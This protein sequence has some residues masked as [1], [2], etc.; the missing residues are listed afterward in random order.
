MGAGIVDAMG[1]GLVTPRGEEAA[2]RTRRWSF[3]AAFAVL[4]VSLSSVAPVV[5]Q[6]PTTE[7]HHGI[8][9]AD[10]DLS[11]DSDANFYRFANGGWLDRTTIP[12]DKAAYGVF[13][14]LNDLTTRQL[15]DLLD[16]LA[17]G[18]VLTEGSDEWKAVRLYQQGIDRSTRNAQGIAPVKPVLD[19]IDALGNLDAL[20]RF[21][22]DAAFKGVP[23]LFPIFVFGDLQDST[24][25]AAYVGGPWLGLP[26]R[27]Y[28]LEDDAANQAVR[29]AYVE[30]SA[31]L[32]T[33]AGH[34]EAT[35]KEAAQ[36]VYDLERQL[37]EPTLTREEQQDFSLYYNP[38]SIDELAATYPAMDW[39]GYVRALGLSGVDRLIVT[40]IK[41]LKA[42]DGIV[43]QAP[44]SALKDYLTLQVLWGFSNNLSDDIEATAF[45]FQGK[46]LGGAQQMEPIEKRALEQ[47]N[48]VMGEAVGK[49]YVAE[50]FPPAA[51]E[52]ITK[53]VD[54]LLEA[55]RLR[56]ERNA[57]MSP[58][59]KANALEKL[60]KIGVKV[61]Y[62]DK[63][64]DY[65]AVEIEGSYAL[66]AL[67]A[68]NAEYRRQLAL[69]GKPVD[70]SEWTFAPQVVNAGYDPFNNDITFPAAI[71]QPPF[72][73]YQADPAS[74]F[75]AIGYVIG[76]EITHG[77]D[78]QGSQFDA[79]GNLANWWTD[80]DHA[81]FDAL[82]KRV[83]AQYG[84]IEVLP[85]VFV[86]GQITV[87]ENVADIGGIRVSYEAMENY[88]ARNGRP[89]KVDGFTQEQRF[90]IAAAQV[91]REKIR[92]EALTTQVKSDVHSPARVRGTQPLR[93]TD[94]F[95]EVFDVRPSDAMYLA[96]KDR[97]TIW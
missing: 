54:A 45:E 71:L 43:R 33:L 77:F 10:M 39:T 58:E 75:G 15:L 40:E 76:H 68:V 44:L 80:E 35:A 7:V 56:L 69:V 79:E 25:N 28:Y 82:N 48:G 64:R 30:T 8:N 29:T 23:G 14:E 66:S 60:L 17:K 67:S 84:A 50:Y 26:N 61:G 22:Q 2:M 62:P 37:A 51:K 9:L 72:F 34:D 21:L 88:L 89:G 92:D 47:V 94:A 57:W 27:D 41:Y 31:K 5:A 16:R 53:L 97:I 91:W 63:W 49:L 18:G 73:D 90:F 12:P 93:N 20:H 83:V 38:L 3:V 81:R 24:I 95:F 70:K 86:D 55:F 32:L 46:V 52:Q 78:L 36:A 11:V 42:L 74:N 59:T 13:D 65:G 6:Q 1:R 87:T 85:G 4:L 19:E 96:P